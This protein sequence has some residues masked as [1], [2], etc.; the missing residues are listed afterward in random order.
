ML[1]I[2]VQKSVEEYLLVFELLH[3]R[4]VQDSHPTLKNFNSFNFCSRSSTSLLIYPSL[5]DCIILFR[6]ICNM[7]LSYLQIPFS[8]APYTQKRFRAF[9]YCFLF[10]RESRTTSSLLESIQKRRK[11]FPCVR[12]LYFSNL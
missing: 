11:A 8:L 9:L 3:L 5:K 7:Y 4:L 1:V 6:H 10:S 12:G 2:C